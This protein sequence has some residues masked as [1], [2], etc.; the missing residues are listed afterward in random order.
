MSAPKLILISFLIALYL[1]SVGAATPEQDFLFRAKHEMLLRDAD[2]ALAALASM[3]SALQSM[4]A[5]AGAAQLAPAQEAFGELVRRWKAVEAV[6]IAGALDEEFLDHPGY[7]DHYHRGNESPVDAISSV[8]RSDAPLQQAMFKT[9]SKG[10]N[11]L[12]YLLFARDEG[13]PRR[14]QAALIAIDH[15]SSRLAEV[16]GFY[17]RDT[18]FEAG[19][20]NSLKLL[21]HALVDSSYRLEDWRVGEP[22]GFTGK[23]KGTPDVERLEYWRSG[24]SMAA[25]E[26]ILAT[27]AEFFEIGRETGYFSARVGDQGLEEIDFQ[28]SK[29]DAAKELAHKL[30]QRPGVE[31]TSADFH[32]LYELLETVYRTYYFLLVDELGVEAKIMES[33]GD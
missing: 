15:I 23:H 22:G 16:D 20:G 11:A 1:P 17:R 4:P 7:I 33:D 25:I 5:E 2:G 24:M 30:A 9:S 14:W 8:L 3:K 21:V 32:D 12:E 28:R 18:S 27:H 29:I 13:S 6:Y 19:D 31:V 26:S 10:I